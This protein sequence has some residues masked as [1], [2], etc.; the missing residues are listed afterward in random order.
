MG[1]EAV[2]AETGWRGGAVPKGHGDTDD[3]RGCSQ[4]SWLSETSSIMHTFLLS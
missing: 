4:L 1:G 2:T 3:N